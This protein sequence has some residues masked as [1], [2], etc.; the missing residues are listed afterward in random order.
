MALRTANV[1]A[2]IEPEVKEK[3]ESIMS[4]LGISASVVINMLYKQIILTNSIPFPLSIPVA[5]AARD[6]MNT[7]EFDDMMKTGLAEAK[8]DYS[9]PASDVFADLKQE[10]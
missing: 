1:L 4:E 8:A 10:I 5:P 7:I 9:R 6:E 3:A 2:R